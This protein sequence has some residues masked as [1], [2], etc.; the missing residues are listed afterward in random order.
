MTR[1]KNPR[2]SIKFASLQL[3]GVSALFV[4]A[5]SQREKKH[6]WWMV[7]T[8]IIR[9]VD[10]IIICCEGERITCFAISRQC[11]GGSVWIRCWLACTWS[12]CKWN[13]TGRNRGQKTR[14]SGRPHNHPPGGCTST[15]I[16]RETRLEMCIAKTAG[17]WR[18]YWGP[19]E[20]L[21]GWRYWSDAVE[22][23]KENVRPNRYFLGR[24]MKRLDHRC[25]YFWQLLMDYF[26]RN[27]RKLFWPIAKCRP[28]SKSV[29]LMKWKIQFW[30]GY[31]ELCHLS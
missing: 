17:R 14:H 31:A 30:W 15:K 18:T 11:G 6:Q 13:E 21:D 9:N 24:R 3:N 12:D 5:A 22:S 4:H 28:S 26:Q 23:S 27:R 29:L 16:S 25:F 7:S 1:I 8:F 10:F 19:P 20:L 2:A